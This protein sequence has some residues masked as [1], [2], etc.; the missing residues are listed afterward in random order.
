MA[1]EA[2]VPVLGERC[3]LPGTLLILSDLSFVPG[4]FSVLGQASSSVSRHRCTFKKQTNNNDHTLDSIC[5]KLSVENKI[6]LGVSTL[7]PGCFGR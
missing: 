7:R 1:I 3:G 6:S 4:Y 2:F 5:I